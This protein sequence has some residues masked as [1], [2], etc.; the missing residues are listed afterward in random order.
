MRGGPWVSSSY[1]SSVRVDLGLKKIDKRKMELFGKDLFD[2]KEKGYEHVFVGQ[3]PLKDTQIEEGP[4]D[5]RI[6][7]AHGTNEGVTSFQPALPI[8]GHEWEEKDQVTPPPIRVG[9]TL[10]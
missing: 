10:R 2:L 9:S 8:K 4:G 1:S 3:F 6:Y 5:G 7:H